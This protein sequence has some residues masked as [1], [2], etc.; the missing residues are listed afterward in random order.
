MSNE[1]HHE[2][3]GGTLTDTSDTYINTSH[4]CLVL[5]QVVFVEQRLG[6]WDAD[7]LKGIYA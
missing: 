3:C 6:H 1:A 7:R 2:G 5:A 4:D